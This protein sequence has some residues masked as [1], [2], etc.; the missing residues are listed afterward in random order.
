MNL[1]GDLGKLLA[2]FDDVKDNLIDLV[3]AGFAA[4]GAN[5]AWAKAEAAVYPGDIYHPAVKPALKMIA[6]ALLGPMIEG[7]GRGWVKS[8]GRGVG[9][10]LVG[11]GAIGVVNAFAPNLLPTVAGL[12]YAEDPLLLADSFGG[13]NVMVESLGGDNVTVESTRGFAGVE[14]VLQ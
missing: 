2:S 1:G 10:G 3:P 13:D 11:S 9:I 14:S 4:A 6:G 8:V 5:I 7:M 12:G